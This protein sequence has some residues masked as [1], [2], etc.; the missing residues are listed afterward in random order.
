MA[1]Y[2]TVTSPLLPPLEAFIPY[3]Q[4]IWESKRLSNGGPFHEQL[5]QALAVSRHA[6][7]LPKYPDSDRATQGRVIDIMFKS[8][9]APC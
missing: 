6:L 2:A 8:Q 1:E 3:L 4:D 5:Q 9:R 7:C